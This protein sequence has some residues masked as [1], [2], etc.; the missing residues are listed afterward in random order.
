MK[1]VSDILYGNSNESNAPPPPKKIKVQK[2]EP[3]CTVSKPSEGRSDCKNEAEPQEIC[4]QNMESA[5]NV[6]LAKGVTLNININ[7]TK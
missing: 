1:Q 4:D 6:Q 5:H 7:V 2:S 3:T